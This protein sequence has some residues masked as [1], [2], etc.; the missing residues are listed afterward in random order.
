MTVTFTLIAR[1]PPTGRADFLAY[2]D[3]VLPL[4]A[5]HGG[6]LN[7]RLRTGAG[8]IEIHIVS[9]P[10]AAAFEAYRADPDRAAQQYL[11]KRSG[12]VLEL[13]EVEDVPDGGNGAGTS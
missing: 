9:F 11:L 12:A 7:R 6:V 13:L 2:E 8:L 10:T 5:R 4:M 3:A 1:I